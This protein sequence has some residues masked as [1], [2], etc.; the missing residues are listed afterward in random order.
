MGRP[1]RVVRSA[2]DRWFKA[3][4]YT[5]VLERLFAAV[6]RT[7]CEH[8]FDNFEGFL[9]GLSEVCTMVANVDPSVEMKIVVFFP[10][11]GRTMMVCEECR[12]GEPKVI[13]SE[14]DD[15]KEGGS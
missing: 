4:R 12:G 1:K 6:R 9:K 2:H 13:E 14:S 11:E 7:F 10:H 3:R 15:D 8:H 5:P